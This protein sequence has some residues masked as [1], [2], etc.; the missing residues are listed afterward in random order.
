[1][2]GPPY[3]HPNPT[4]GSNAIGEFEI[5]VSPIGTIT[6]FDVWTTV[7]SQYANSEILTQLIVD[8]AAYIDQTANFD[9]FFELIWNVDTAQ[10]YGLDIWGRI[11]DVSRT[12]QVPAGS[13]FGFAEAS[14]GPD[15]GI[16]GF[17]SASYYSG[18]PLTQNYNL[19]DEPYRLLIFAKA[20]SN[21]TD[22]SI[23]AINQILLN[24]FPNR[25]NCYVSEGYP[26]DGLFFGFAEAFDCQPFGQ[27]PFFSNSPQPPMTMSYVFEFA[28]SAVE[29]AI[30]SQ[31]GAIPKP[32]G[33]QARVVQ[34]I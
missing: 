24:L 3:P 18:A 33:V 7:L 16:D 31:S 29:L 19:T 2:S 6:A 30:V 10:G 1:M 15:D 11:V 17:G 20:L 26:F 21:I 9:A 5:G 12:L 13:Y 28:L 22:C 27:A 34:L 14:G 32:T 25:G 23:P 4:P 8:M